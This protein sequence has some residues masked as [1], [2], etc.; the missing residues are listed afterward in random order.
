VRLQSCDRV[1][2]PDTKPFLDLAAWQPRQLIG[3]DVDEFLQ[4]ANEHAAQSAHR[5]NVDGPL[6]MFPVQDLSLQF[7][8]FR[9]GELETLVDDRDRLIVSVGGVNDRIA[10]RLKALGTLGRESVVWQVIRTPATD[11]GNIPWPRQPKR[12]VVASTP[13]RHRRLA[14]VQSPG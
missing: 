2:G 9:T 4:N 5:A 1:I 12:P 8:K 14:G 6:D 10:R 11:I 7:D 13:L 3:Q